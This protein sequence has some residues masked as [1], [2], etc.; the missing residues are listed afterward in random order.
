MKGFSTLAPSIYIFIEFQ[1]KA[2]RVANRIDF[3]TRIMNIGFS[4]IFDQ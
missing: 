2:K 3:D 4:K 1:K